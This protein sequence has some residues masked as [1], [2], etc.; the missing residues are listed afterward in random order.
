MFVSNDVL[1]RLDLLQFQADAFTDASC[2]RQ[3]P[4]LGIGVVEVQSWQRARSRSGQAASTLSSDSGT[5][6]K[7]CDIPLPCG[8]P[9]CMQFW[10]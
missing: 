3:G 10:K 2:D 4:G 1:L 9:T 5:L 7:I 6:I 8:V